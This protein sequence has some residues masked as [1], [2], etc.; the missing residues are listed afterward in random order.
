MNRLHRTFL[1]ITTI[2]ACFGTT[3]TF[4]VELPRHQPQVVVLRNGSLLQGVVQ[5]ENQRVIV[6]D[7]K[8]RI[9]KVALN[10]VDFICKDL[11]E[12]YRRKLSRLQPDDVSQHLRLAQW[13]LRYD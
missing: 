5:R 4:A 9:T 3:T 8:D 10:D 7:G 13:C 2:A 1:I 6:A 12:A 11:S